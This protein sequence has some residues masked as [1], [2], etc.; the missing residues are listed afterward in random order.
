M[1]NNRR[2]VGKDS[3]EVERTRGGRRISGRQHEIQT[4][5][6]MATF[7]FHINVKTINHTEQVAHILNS[8]HNFYIKHPAGTGRETNCSSSEASPCHKVNGFTNC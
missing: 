2:T 8:G 6:T 3:G 5:Y 7:I 1:I 4:L